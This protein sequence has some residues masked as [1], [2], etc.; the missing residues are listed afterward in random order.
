MNYKGDGGYRMAR[1]YLRASWFAV[2]HRPIAL[3]QPEN[4]SGAFSPSKYKF[5]EQQLQP[6]ERRRLGQHA[7]FRGIAEK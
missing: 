7:S 6:A 1:L 3:I 4:S 5:A 2:A